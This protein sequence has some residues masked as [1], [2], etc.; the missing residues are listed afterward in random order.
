M[1]SL[2]KTIND[3]AKYK[4][5]II[6]QIIELTNEAG[7]NTTKSDEIGNLLNTYFTEIG[8]KLAH[9]VMH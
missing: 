3:I 4:K 1:K 2:W 9:V 6:C 8:Q 7:E 5:R